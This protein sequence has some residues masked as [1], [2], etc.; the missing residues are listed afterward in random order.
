M[1]R[2]TPR[3][4]RTAL[5]WLLQEGDEKTVCDMGKLGRRSFV[6]RLDRRD[7]EVS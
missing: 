4:D 7:A 1:D 2:R 6:L 3:D 5:G